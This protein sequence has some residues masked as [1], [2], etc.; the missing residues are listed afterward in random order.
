MS[1]RRTG[2]GGESIRT[3]AGLGLFGALCFALGLMQLGCGSG[4]DRTR[5]IQDLPPSPATDGG[6]PDVA[7]DGGVDAGT[8]GGWWVRRRNWRPWSVAD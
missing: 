1:E 7:P 6:I 5:N 4:S 3:S 8:D 2:M